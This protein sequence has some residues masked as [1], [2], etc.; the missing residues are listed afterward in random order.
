MQ[1][2]GASMY[3]LPVAGSGSGA[4]FMEPTADLELS[5]ECAGLD[6]MDYTSK[7]DPMVVVQAKDAAGQWRELGRTETVQDSLS[8]KFATSFTIEYFFERTQWFRFDVYD[9]DS[10]SADLSRHDFI[11]R[12]TELRLCDIVARQGRLSAELTRP[13]K[14]GPSGTLTAIV[15][16]MSGSTDNVVLKLRGHKLANKDGMFGKS[17]PFVAIHRQVAGKWVK[18]HETPAIMDNLNPSWLEFTVSS[19]HLTAN[20]K[21]RP[22]L[23]E[24]WDWESSGAHQMIGHFTTNLLQLE[25]QEVRQGA[26]LHPK[27]KKKDVGTLLFE[28]VRVERSHSFCDFLMGGCEVSLM[29]AVDFTASNGD[30]RQPGTLHYAQA[31][32]PN[33]YEQA[34]SSVGSIVVAYDH[35]G[36]VPAYGFG[37]RFPNG[38]VSHC[39]AL[40]GSADAS[41]RGV[42]EMLHFYRQAIAN[43]Q[44][45]GPT[46]FAEFIRTAAATAR[47][48]QVSQ[49]NQQY[50]VLLVL[51][52][53]VITDME[54][55]VAEVV[56]ASD[57]PLSIIIVGVG[58]ADFTAMDRLDADDEPLR[59]TRGR[60]AQRDI[61]QFVP[62]SQFK[63]AGSERLAMEVLAEVP[64]QVISFFKSKGIQPNPPPPPPPV[65]AAALSAV[66]AGGEAPPP[67]YTST[68]GAEA[69]P[70][71]YAGGAGGGGAVPVATVQAVAVPAPAPAPA[72]AY[73]R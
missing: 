57:L 9:V 44:L 16:E 25:T 38:A 1:A 49:A 24:V 6:N 62:F 7:S 3:A 59:D 19:R 70:A 47:C 39:F 20:D 18:C 21:Q 53:G 28:T 43:L 37:A 30:P 58:N 65:A 60:V 61:V 51:T 13:G 41:C 14:R 68:A 8:P 12:T 50:F 2:A 71:Y 66:A 31:G 45:Y 56:S 63:A 27:G 33:E 29:A 35:D 5:L 11:G 26:L 54:Q 34:I 15:E 40:N 72:P 17:D 46:N 10:D 36:L 48:A 64:G 69:P 23:F 4:T 67:A 55:T 32:V 42:P 22:I 52:D 73:H